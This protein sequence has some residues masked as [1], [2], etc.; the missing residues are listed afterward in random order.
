VLKEIVFIGLQLM[1]EFLLKEK[2]TNSWSGSCRWLELFIIIQK[3]NTFA[4]IWNT[5]LCILLII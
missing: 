5:G 2:H 4:I 3:L 1:L